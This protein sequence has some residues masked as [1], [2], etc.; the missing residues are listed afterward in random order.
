MGDLV[1]WSEKPRSIAAAVV[2]QL[3]G[4]IDPDYSREL[5]DRVVRAVDRTAARGHTDAAPTADEVRRAQNALALRGISTS[6]ED[7][8]AALEAAFVWGWGS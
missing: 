5:A 7:V 1:R 8:R 4:G 6:P 3:Y 2:L